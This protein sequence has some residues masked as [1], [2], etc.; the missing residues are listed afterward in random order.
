MVNFYL[1]RNFV[2]ASLLEQI[3]I[4]EAI[5][6]SILKVGDLIRGLGFKPTNKDI[7]EILGNPKK[8][9]MNTSTCNFDQ[10]LGYVK[11]AGEKQKEGTYE[12]FVEGKLI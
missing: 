1:F 3:L 10:F 7:A 2:N 11:Q 12:D 6:T 4:L 9:E 5:L 8:E